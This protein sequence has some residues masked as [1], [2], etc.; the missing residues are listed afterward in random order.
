MTRRKA[1]KLLNRVR[2]LE[3]ELSI[4]NYYNANIIELREEL[5]ELRHERIR[6]VF[7]LGELASVSIP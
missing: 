4:M 3:N 2:D 6:N 1:N 5:R 7:I